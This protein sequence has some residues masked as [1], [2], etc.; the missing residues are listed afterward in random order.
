MLLAT[1]PQPSSQ[2][3][4]GAYYTPE[5]VAVQLVRWAVREPADRLLDPACG[6]GRFI[7]A[8]RPS[9]GVEHDAIALQGA[10]MRAPSASL[11]GG[12]FFA[13]A[14]RT[15]ER[16]DC[17]VGNPP[18]IRYQ[19]FSGATRQRA[20]ALCKAQGV[21]FSRLT[22]SWPPFLVAA[23]SLLR[24]GGRMAFVVPAAIG[25]APY[26]AP[27][28]EH[29]LA[30]FASVQVVAIRDKLFPKLSE[31]CWLLLADGHGGSAKEI[32]FTRKTRLR[33]AD[34]LAPPASVRVRADEWRSVWNRRLRPYLLSAPARSLYQRVA[35]NTSSRRFGE[36]AAASIGYVSGANA[37]FHLRPSQARSIGIPETYLQPTVRNGRIL[38]TG[39]LTC[40]TVEDW[41]R[42]DE[43]MLLLRL[44]KH[45]ALPAEVQRYLDGPEGVAARQAY[46]CRTRSPWYAV[47][48]V[49]VP[50]YFLSYM[51]GRAPS[52]VRNRA[53]ATC[54]NAVHAVKVRDEG[55]AAAFKVWSSPYVELSCELEGHALGGGL[56][57]LEPGEVS[58][59]VL[60]SA[61]TAASLPK[62]RVAD[63][64]AT[65]REWRHCRGDRTR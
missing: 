23:A 15:P 10:R 57:K 32:L 55:A 5:G 64:I 22:A 13:W 14:A 18:F 37:F 38:P 7:A 29:L 8:H 43:P 62:A 16:F 17:A 28:L 30:R 42:A 24:P 36:V 52:L 56:L 53:A 25:H 9:F 33:P 21:A 65:L 4:N 34:A 27:L 26:A 58:R 1:P 54:T 6:D 41:R 40:R 61:A 3:A 39:E 19:T 49:H 2:K 63:A 59:I 12:D 11:H 45:G 50:D 46:K 48:G 44:P 31:D 60:P 51:A 47:P 20:L 35:R